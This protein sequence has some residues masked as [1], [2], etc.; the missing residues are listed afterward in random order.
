MSI[1]SFYSLIKKLEE[2]WSGYGCSI[3][4]PYTSELGAATLH[5][6]TIFSSISAKDAKIAY[7]QPVIRPADGR[8][9][10]NPNRLYQ[11]HQYQVLIKPSPDNLQDLYL[12]SLKHV[13]ID[14]R[15]HDIRFVE[16]DW[17]NPSVGA[18]GM[19][20]EVWCD[21]MEIS[22]FTYMQ[23]VGG[24]ALSSIPG[25]LAYGL[26]RIAMYMQDVDN[27]GNLLYSKDTV[28]YMEVYGENERQ[29]SIAALESYEY[30]L[31]LSQF[32]DNAAQAK[33]FIERKLPLVAYDHCVKTSHI[34]NLMDSRGF[35]SVSERAKYILD[36]RGL[37]KQCCELFVEQEGSCA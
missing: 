2:Y 36:I 17:E 18:W 35:I 5:P 9:G 16:D 11:H 25:E 8:Y 7:V 34:L 1:S 30:E 22:Q 23:Q 6:A 15:N 37:V 4:L 21:G 28:K 3:L 13:G 12:D 24:V 10:K 27:V 33:I 26:E 31:L 14:I 20:W 32:N 19:G 29:F